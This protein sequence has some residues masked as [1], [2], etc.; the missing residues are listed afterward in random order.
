[1][2]SEHAIYEQLKQYMEGLVSVNTHSHA[3]EPERLHRI[4]LYD[5]IMQSYLRWCRIPLEETRESIAHFT[6]YVKYN[7]YFRWLEKGLQ[8]L[9]GTDVPLSTDTYWDYDA[10]VRANHEELHYS[11]RVDREILHFDHTVLDRDTVPGWD[12]G[13]PG[14][15]DPVYRFDMWMVGYD[16]AV[17][18]HNKLNPF[19][20]YDMDA[21]MRFD[22][23]VRACQD[24]VAEMIAGGCVGLKCAKAYDR[25][26]LFIDSTPAQAARAWR[27]PDAT[28]EEIRCFEDHMLYRVMDAAADLKVPVQWHT[29]LAAMEESAARYLVPVIRRYPEI[30]FCIFHGSYP[31]T[32]DVAGLVRSF[33]NVRADICWM[34]ILST[35]TTVRFVREM[36]EAGNL[37]TMMW[38]ADAFMPEETA[39]A[40]FAAHHALARAFAGLVA[41][42][43]MALEDA[44]TFVRHIMRDNAAE[45]FGF[46][47]AA[48]IAAGGE[49]TGET[50]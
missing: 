9:C 13:C 49:Q 48:G 36:V 46:R 3:W 30:T 28:P 43:D 41:E 37:G 38:G 21:D 40:Y 44:K 17:R 6:E 29:G 11:E 5:V 47:A 4:G 16:P 14:S 50:S 35:Q 34:P 7:A 15:Y 1:M 25:S 18:D 31:W 33:G 2:S 19:S 45:V 27:N 42:G 23:Y 20:W 39:G 10:A 12:N 26:N 24:K 8:V 32:E 22:E